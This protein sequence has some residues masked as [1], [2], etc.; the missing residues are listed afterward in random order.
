MARY[1]GADAALKRFKEIHGNESDLLNCYNA[2]W[3][4]EELKK[5]LDK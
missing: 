2:D 3:N 4:A 1:I 5:E